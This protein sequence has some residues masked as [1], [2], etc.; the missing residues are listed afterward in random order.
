MRYLVTGGAGFVGSH[1]ARRLLGDGHEVIVLDDLSAGCP[2][3][4]ADLFHSA[5]FRFVAGTALDVGLAGAMVARADR[6]F[7]L[8]AVVGVGRVLADPAAAFD[9][10]VRAARAVL[11]AAAR[12]G[13]KVLL[14]SSSEVYGPGRALRNGGFREE[15]SA[16]ARGL[17]G[18]RWA[19]AASKLASER[20]GLEL[21]REA[22]LP[23]VIARLFN[24]IGSGQSREQGM[25]VPRFVRQACC[26]EPLTVHGDG[27][28]TR[29]FTW[30]G[31]TVECLVRLMES[32]AAEGR[33]VNVGSTETVSIRDLAAM[34]AAA[35]PSR[36][37]IVHVPYEQAFGPGFEDVRHRRPDTAR[38]RRLAGA[39]PRTPLRRSLAMLIENEIGNSLPMIRMAAV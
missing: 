37:P 26:G 7:H 32:P 20:R 38:L 36:P 1:L 28:Q 16:G 30:V 27:L 24:V 23:V 2:G 35:A 22:R 4:I 25:V 29:S 21:S 9:V 12:R 10:N 31:D 18:P 5:R 13:R 3:N 39:V 6:V 14:A 19:Y 15:E 17:C 11:D 33:V 34:V 8:A